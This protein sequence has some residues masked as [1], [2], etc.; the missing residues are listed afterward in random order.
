MSE[1]S[2][3]LGPGRLPG[4]EELQAPLNGPE[5][6]SN[7]LSTE[8]DSLFS[9]LFLLK[10]TKTV[11]PSFKGSSFST[12]KWKSGIFQLLYLYLKYIFML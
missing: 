4:S 8:G 3:W 1:P 7:D 9:L 2:C 12:Y 6:P 11:N 10:K 5:H